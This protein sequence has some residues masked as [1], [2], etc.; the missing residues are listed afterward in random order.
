MNPMM[1]LICAVCVGQVEPEKAAYWQDH[2]VVYAQVT[3]VIRLS[4]GNLLAPGN[5][6]LVL[7][8]KAAI[9]GK[10]DPCT[11]PEIEVSFSPGEYPIFQSEPHE[12]S[13]IVTLIYETPHPAA[14]RPLAEAKYE[15]VLRPMPFFP[16]KPSPGFPAKRVMQPVT[17]YVEVEGFDDP[18]VEAIR[19]GIIKLRKEGK[20]APPNLE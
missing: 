20:P 9:S 6:K 15:M 2:A 4:P 17:G 8:P 11:E 14:P 5:F 13:M 19:T 7:H 10:V 3:K 18:K 16:K 12:N 1:T